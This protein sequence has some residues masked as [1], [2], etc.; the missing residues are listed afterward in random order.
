MNILT[1]LFKGYLGQGVMG[2]M[3]L[4]MLVLYIRKDRDVERLYDLMFRKTLEVSDAWK[5]MF[6]EVEETLSASRHELSRTRGHVGAT[7]ATGHIGATGAAGAEGHTGETGATGAEGPA[8]P[9]GHSS[10]EDSDEQD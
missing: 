5:A 10:K 4:T 6:K 9:A 8:G 1:E 7:G 2:L 3:A